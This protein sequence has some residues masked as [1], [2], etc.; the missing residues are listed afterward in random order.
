MK[1][2]LWLSKY[3]S[4]I[5][6]RLQMLFVKYCCFFSW[7][8]VILPMAPLLC[9][10]SLS[11]HSVGSLFF[12]VFPNAAAGDLPFCNSPPLILTHT[13]GRPFLLNCIANSNLE[14][15]HLYE[16]IFHALFLLLS[17]TQSDTA[18]GITFQGGH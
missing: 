5:A 9:Y 13:G 14:W 7:R 1:C 10:I 16:F 17:S 11:A 2:V 6:A 12:A 3:R 4:S 8:R 15:L 18:A